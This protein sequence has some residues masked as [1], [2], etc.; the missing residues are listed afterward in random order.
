[1]IQKPDDTEMLKVLLDV[2][3]DHPDAA[4][5]LGVGIADAPAAVRTAVID[6]DELEILER[7]RLDGLDSATHPFFH[8]VNGHDNAYARNVLHVEAPPVPST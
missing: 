2:L 4:V 1:M 6:E 8:I 5:A 7:L 3:V